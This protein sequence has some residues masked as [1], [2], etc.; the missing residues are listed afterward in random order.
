V[1]DRCREGDDEHR[2]ECPAPRR[3]TDLEHQPERKDL[4]QGELWDQE[5]LIRADADPWLQDDHENDADQAHDPPGGPTAHGAEHRGRAPLGPKKLAPA[6]IALRTTLPAERARSAAIC[7]ITTPGN[8][9]SAAPCSAAP[10]P[11]T[12]A[13]IAR[14]SL[15]GRPPQIRNSVSESSAN[16]AG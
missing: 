7:S 5:V 4:Q 2:S 15:S 14:R 8:R 13:G 1:N 16:G 11:A 10:M 3:P 6:A 9:T 12:I